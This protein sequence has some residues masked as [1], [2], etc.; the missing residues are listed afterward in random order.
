MPAPEL[1]IRTEQQRQSSEADCSSG[2][3]SSDMLQYIIVLSGKSG[4]DFPLVMEYGDTQD[5]LNPGN[6]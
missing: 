1:H 2:Q 3:L 5:L 4:V 6:G